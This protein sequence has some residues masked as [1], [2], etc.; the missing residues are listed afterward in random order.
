MIIYAN[1]EIDQTTFERLKT[2]GN[3]YNVRVEKK[4]MT[5]KLAVAPENAKSL[6]A[7]NCLDAMTSIYKGIEKLKDFQTI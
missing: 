2:I 4:R 1:Q 6:T 5:G 7:M 3:D